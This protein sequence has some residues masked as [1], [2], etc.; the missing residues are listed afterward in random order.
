M[1]KRTR[2]CLERFDCTLIGSVGGTYSYRY[3][4]VRGWVMYLKKPKG[5]DINL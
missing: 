1:G 2:D 4:C 5:N 3:V